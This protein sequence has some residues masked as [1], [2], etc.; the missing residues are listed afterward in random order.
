MSRWPTIRFRTMEKST[1]RF[2]AQFALPIL[3]KRTTH[4]LNAGM[5]MK[6]PALLSGYPVIKRVKNSHGTTCALYGGS[7]SIRS[8][9]SNAYGKAQ[10]SAVKNEGNEVRTVQKGSDILWILK[11]VCGILG[12]EKYRDAAARLDDDEREP[13][14]VD[15]LGGRQEMIAV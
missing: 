8:E 5:S 1:P 14:L 4:S 15:T 10:T 9:N 7:K 11:D 2:H 12:I 6:N 13:V 3:T